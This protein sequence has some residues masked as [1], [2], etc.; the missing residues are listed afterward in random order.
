MDSV[1]G[2]MALS[3]YYFLKHNL[4]FIPVVNTKRQEFNLRLDIV[5]HFEYCK[6]SPDEHVYFY[7]DLIE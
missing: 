4:S 2:S 5:Q 7:Q 6:L 1:V 3:Y